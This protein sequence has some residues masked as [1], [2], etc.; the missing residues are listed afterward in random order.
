MFIPLS[1]LQNSA[2]LSKTQQNSAKLS[3]TQQNSA[4]LS[5]TQQNS[6]KPKTTIE[7]VWLNDNV[8]TGAD[9][10][11]EHSPK[12]GRAFTPYAAW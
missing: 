4:K 9:I 12:G 6:A 10:E 5:K 7:Y 2:K 11:T 3:K 8:I 1:L